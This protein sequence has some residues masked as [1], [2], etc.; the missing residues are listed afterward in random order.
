MKNRKP[1]N[2]AGGVIILGALTWLYLFFN[3]RPP[4]IDERPHKAVGEVLAA[5]A[6]KLMQPGAKLIVI[7][8]TLKPFN[9]PAAD[10]QLDGLV[11]TLNKSGVKV[12]ALRTIAVDPLRVTSVPPGEFFDLLRQCDENDVIVSLLGPPTLG[13]DQLAKLGPKRPRVLAVCSGAM[14]ARVDLKTLFDQK[15]LAAAVLSRVNEPVR[16]TGT[17]SRPPFEQQFRLITPAN[18]SELPAVVAARP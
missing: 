14:P 12:S 11:R 2:V 4:D 5:E 13:A 9:V 8:R 15:L 10:A 7:A 1:I 18:I 16:T 3:P 6:L 17:D